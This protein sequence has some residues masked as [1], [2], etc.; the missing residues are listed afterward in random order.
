MVRVMAILLISIIHFTLSQAVFSQITIGLPKLP[1]IGKHKP[2]QGNEGTV[3]DQKT[4]TTDNAQARQKNS[5]D[6]RIYGPQRPTDA[7]VLLK[8]SVYVQA[9]AHDEYWKL[10]NA[11]NYSSWVPVTRFQ[12]FAN[13][14]KTYNYTVE[15]FNPDG[16]SWYSEKMDDTGSKHFQSPSPWG[17]VLDTKSSIGTG[18]YSFKITDQDTKEVI[19]TGK[20][21]VGKF[22]TSN[23]RPDEKNKS[24]FFVDQDWL[25]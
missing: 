13:Y 9:V 19:F 18:L 10:P 25:M 1:K 11:K 5:D 8:S 14:D 3:R 2:E 20:F 6:K 17:G 16:T 7:A 22:S 15:Y 4:T 23:G 21:K 24:D 12:T